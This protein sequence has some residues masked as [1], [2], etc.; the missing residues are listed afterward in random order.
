[1]KRLFALRCARITATLSVAALFLVAG[2]QAQPS[3]VLIDLESDQTILSEEA[4][5]KIESPAAVPMMTLYTALTL[6]EESKI[7]LEAPIAAAATDEPAPK[8]AS[9]K[10]AAGRKPSKAAAAPRAYSAADALLAFA[11]SADQAAG[12]ALLKLAGATEETFTARMNELAKELQLQNTHFTSPFAGDADGSTTS[13][14]DA[15]NL[16]KAL[17]VKFPQAKL[18][19]AERTASFDG[20]TIDNTNPFLSSSVSGVSVVETHQSANAVVLAEDQKS[21]GRV[22]G[23]LAVVLDADDKKTLRE[24]VSTTLLRGWRDYETIMVYSA[25]AIVANVPIYRGESDEI[26]VKVSAP[27]FVT[28]PRERLLELGDGAIELSIRRW[29]PLIAP[30]RAGEQLGTL[31]ISSNGEVLKTVPITTEQGVGEGNFLKRLTD[32]IRLAFDHDE[33]RQEAVR[34]AAEHLDAGKDTAKNTTSK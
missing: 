30:I 4:S 18:W 23:L 22:R 32:N 8:N 33:R 3:T 25:G 6:L 27:V 1:M 24:R 29:S 16:A 19:T 13:A 14:I 7:P 9:H 5:L 21:N 20:R 15:A 26:P 2:A 17:F 31:S 10:K 28:I 12:K 34:H 11:V